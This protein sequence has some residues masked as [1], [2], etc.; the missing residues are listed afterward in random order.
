MIWKAY[1]SALKS[2]WEWTV[3][4]WSRRAFILS[5]TFHILWV[6]VVRSW[7]LSCVHFY[8]WENLSHHSCQ[9]CV[10]GM[11]MESL[12]P[13]FMILVL[14]FEIQRIVRGNT[15]IDFVIINYSTLLWKSWIRKCVRLC[16]AWCFLVFPAIYIKCFVKHY[17][18]MWSKIILLERV[19]WGTYKIGE[20]IF[21]VHED[22]VPVN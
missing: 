2:W 11:C 19:T 21:M 17:H 22:E 9:S 4:P 15:M 3:Q 6:F 1:Y 14:L 18:F 8:S 16:E 13:G 7:R 5:P 20:D 12:P 10:W